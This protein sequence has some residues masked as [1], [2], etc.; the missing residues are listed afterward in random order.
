MRL[1]SEPRSGTT[2][3]E[4]VAVY[5]VVL[6]LMLALVVGAM[7][8]FRYQEVATLARE[9]ARY[10]CV[11]GTQYAKEAGV[12]APTP[13]DIVDNAVT[14]RAVAL[15]LSR[16]DCA[17]TY[18]TSNQPYHTKVDA[19]GNIVPVQNTVQVTLTYHWVPEALLGGLTLSSTA[20][21]PMAY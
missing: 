2:A 4:G 9:A 10:A 21:M 3:V 6:F 17:I 15:D 16:L 1:R 19:S 18:T 20:V 13:Q 14:N 11:H 5:P 12:T 7:G 8:I